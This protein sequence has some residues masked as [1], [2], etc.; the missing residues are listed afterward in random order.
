MLRVYENNQFELAGTT[1]TVLD[2]TEKGVV[3][4]LL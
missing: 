3:W 4:Q 2:H 1:W